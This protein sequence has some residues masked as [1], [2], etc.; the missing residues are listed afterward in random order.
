MKRAGGRHQLESNWALRPLHDELGEALRAELRGWPGIT[1]RPMM[2]TLSFFHRKKFIGCYVNRELSKSKPDWL[3]RNGEPTFVCIRLRADD[4][5]RA[6]RRPEIKQSRMAFAGW[7]EI[8]LASRKLLSEAVH[9]FGRAY[10]RPAA[11]GKRAP[12]RSSRRRSRT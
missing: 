9:W 3:N 1:L 12:R 10:E 6:L 5:A 4:A 8:P 7:V 2:G 11:P